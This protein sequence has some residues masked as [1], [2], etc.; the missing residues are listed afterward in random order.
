MFP[1]HIINVII[2]AS[3]VKHNLE[4]SRGE[5]KSI[6]F[7]YIFAYHVLSS[8]LMFQG[9]SFYKFI[10]VLRISFSHS[11]KAGLLVTHSLSFPASEYVLIPPSYPKDIF[12]GYSGLTVFFQHLKNVV[13]LLSYLIVSDEKSTAFELVFPFR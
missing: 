13:P 5:G 8:F 10:S 7:T 4:N 12:T 11:S 9:F 6:V 3:T 2:F 1:L